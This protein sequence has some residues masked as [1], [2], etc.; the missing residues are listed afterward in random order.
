M[1]GLNG[2]ESLA[3][4]EESYFPN[5]CY[6]IKSG[7]RERLLKEN[8]LPMVFEVSCGCFR[9]NEYINNKQINATEGNCGSR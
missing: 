1:D 6:L 7:A 5:S 4:F 2:M 9:M 3:R 8:A